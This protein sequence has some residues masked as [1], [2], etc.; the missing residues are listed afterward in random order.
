MRHAYAV[1]CS[2]SFFV[3]NIILFLVFFFF[4]LR[5]NYDLLKIV[6]NTT[7][8]HPL[9][10]YTRFYLLLPQSS[11]SFVKNCWHTADF[12]RLATS[13]VWTLARL[14]LH[15]ECRVKVEVSIEIHKW[16]L[17]SSNRYCLQS[18][19]FHGKY[20]ILI[21]L[22]FRSEIY[23]LHSVGRSFSSSMLMSLQHCCCCCTKTLLSFCCVKWFISLP[24]H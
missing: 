12:V 1:Q 15:G 9:N 11:I 3:Q 17:K 14:K 8:L 22:L 23:I 7:Y 4:S 2:I 19:D 16:H 18:L 13:I 6:E 21:V 24:N 20:F 5:T 10:A